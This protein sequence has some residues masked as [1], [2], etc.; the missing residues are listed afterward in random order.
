M[1]ELN[2][3][4]KLVLASQ[5]PRRKYLLEQAGF[6]PRILCIDVEESYPQGLETSKVAEFI[7][8]KKAS[9]C[10]HLLDPDEICITA[11][12]V[13]ILDNKI[14]GKPDS[15]EEAVSMLNA[16]SN[17]SH[18]VTTGVCISHKNKQDSF[19][20][21]S[22]VHCGHLNTNEINY[23]IDQFKPFDKAGAYGIQEWLGWCK[24]DRIEGSY[25]NIMGLPMYEVYAHLMDL[26]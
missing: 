15:R 4:K 8:S 1:T 6:S 18:L 23:Y 12:T 25:S 7:A 11:D 10:E 19:S 2:F 14:L 3:P 22:T 13:V 5:S 16:L 26:S 20:V 21:H 9:A 17:C 24:I